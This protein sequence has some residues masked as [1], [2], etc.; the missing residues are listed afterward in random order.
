MKLKNEKIIKSKPLKGFTLIEVLAY[1]GVLS[2]VMVVITSFIIWS[3]HSTNKIKVIRETLYNA[4]RSMEIMT[5]EIRKAKNISPTT[6]SSHLYLENTTTTEFYLC[7]AALTTLCQRKGE[8]DPIYL[9][10]ERVE[11]KNLEFT[12]IATS[13]T[14]PSIQ[15]NLKIDYKN[16][17][18]RPELEASV[19]STSTISLRSY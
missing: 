8:A 10:S 19:V 17:A 4:R 16:P 9:T 13:T 6:T 3:V 15:I 7:G 12:Q 18:N 2:I 14:T 11:V 1:I 5:Y